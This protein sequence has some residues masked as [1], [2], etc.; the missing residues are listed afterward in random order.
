MP[1]VKV[2]LFGWVEREIGE[3]LVVDAESVD[4][5]K[6]ALVKAGLTED[7]L[8]ALLVVPRK[9]GKESSLSEGDEVLVFPIV[10][11]G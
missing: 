6:Q 1:K 5:V 4:D 8:K 11:G 3:E 7:D 10:G 2:L 9:G